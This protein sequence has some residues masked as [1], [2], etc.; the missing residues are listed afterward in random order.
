MVKVCSYKRSGTHWLMAL[1]ACNFR[2]DED[3]SLTAHSDGRRWVLTGHKK[4]R[5]PWGK[6]FLTH[7]PIEKVK[8]DKS[9]IIYIHRHPLDVM[10]SLWE[11]HGKPKGLCDYVTDYMINEWKNHVEGYINDGIYSISYADLQ[12]KPVKT[13]QEICTHFGF[14]LEDGKYHPVKKRVGWAEKSKISEREGY[15]LKCIARFREILG[16]DYMGYKI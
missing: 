14:V 15:T 9:K 7:D 12:M 1:M 2:Y 3:L 16:E 8:H 13:L 6:L 10:R 4:A 5:V 11:F